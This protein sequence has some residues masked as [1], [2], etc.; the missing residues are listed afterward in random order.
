MIKKLKTSRKVTMKLYKNKV[1]KETTQYY[2]KIRDVAAVLGIKQPFEFASDIK[3]KMGKDVVK[4]GHA[5][6]N[7][8]ATDDTKR[9]TYISIEDLYNYLTINTNWR[10]KMNLKKRLEL[11]LEL[12]TLLLDM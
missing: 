10:Q 9:A 11:V 3:E 8:L 12:K 5:L 7:L 4:D 2:L 1:T 6:P